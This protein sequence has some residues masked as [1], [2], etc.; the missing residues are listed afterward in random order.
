MTEVE[1]INKQLA[2][3]FGIDTVTGRVMYRVVWA[4]EQFE[5]RLTEY[6]DRGNPLLV[7]EVRLLPKYQWIKGKFILENLMYIANPESQKEL[8]GQK[9][10]YE[11]VF[12][13]DDK[14]GNPLPPNFDV[15]VLVI[16][17]MQAAM[18]GGG[19]VKYKE[20]N[21]VEER[22]QEIE[23]LQQELFGDESEITDAL[24]RGSGIVVPNKYEVN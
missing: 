18:K 23:A 20:G 16:T 24:A 13:F 7:P 15:C 21:P 17:T 19:Y 12:V 8:A 11:V 3:R 5:N 14:N 4:E 6:D 22:K 10:S 1:R 9:L 2:D